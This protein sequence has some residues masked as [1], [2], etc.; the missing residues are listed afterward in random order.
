MRFRT[1]LCPSDCWLIETV[2]RFMLLYQVCH[3]V[4]DLHLRVE[5]DKLNP[6]KAVDKLYVECPYYFFD[7][8]RK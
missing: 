7:M 5:L 1:Q 4:S 6:T 8:E 2:P 3:L